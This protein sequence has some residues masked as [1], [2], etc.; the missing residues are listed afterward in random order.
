MQ[1]SSV[2]EFSLLQYVNY[3]LYKAKR[4]KNKEKEHACDVKTVEHEK[5][6]APVCTVCS[7]YA[8]QSRVKQFTMLTFAHLLSTVLAISFAWFYVSK[9]GLLTFL[10]PIYM[11]VSG[12]LVIYGLYHQN[13]IPLLLHSLV[14]CTCIALI[15]LYAL[16]FTQFMNSRD[17]AVVYVS[18]VSLTVLAFESLSYAIA[19]AKGTI[20]YYSGFNWSKMI[21]S[22]WCSTMLVCESIWSLIPC[23]YGDHHQQQV[24][25]SYN[26]TLPPVWSFRPQ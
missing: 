10:I 7:T 6:I 18:I 12:V 9:L 25:P 11:V 16:P 4:I 24:L 21:A 3:V 20:D 2:D 15:T 17:S 14:S 22:V 23:Q 1:A 8:H 5:P 13:S 26:R 19:F